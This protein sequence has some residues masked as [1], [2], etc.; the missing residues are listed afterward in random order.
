MHNNTCIN[1][2]AWLKK[3]SQLQ[4][5][6]FKNSQIRDVS[7]L[8]SLYINTLYILFCVKTILYTCMQMIEQVANTI[9]Q[10][11]LVCLLH[12][13]APYSKSCW[14]PNWTSQ[15]LSYHFPYIFNRNKVWQSCPSWNSQSMLSVTGIMA[16]GIILLKQCITI[17]LPK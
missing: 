1:N 12:L 8:L 11:I 4:I 2:I 17:L 10:Y 15:A 16:T 14:R 3:W 6:K 13:L 9:L 7:T 5:N